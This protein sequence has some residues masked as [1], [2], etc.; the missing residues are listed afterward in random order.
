MPKN[1]MPSADAKNPN[2]KPKIPIKDNSGFHTVEAPPNP[3]IPLT[4]ASCSWGNP[5]DH[6]GSPEKEGNR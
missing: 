6:T 3:Q 1:L 5:Q 4:H 2:Q